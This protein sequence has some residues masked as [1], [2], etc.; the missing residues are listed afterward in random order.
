M[1]TTA[2]LTEILR[3]PSA[4]A[5]RIREGRD[6]RSLASASILAIVLGSAAY[7][8]VV[9]SYRGGLQILFGGLKFPLVALVTLSL[10]APALLGLSAAFERRMALA[11]AVALM[12][13][14][15]ARTSLVLLAFAPALAL[16]FDMRPEYH[17]GALLAAAGFALA[18]LAGITLLWRGLGEGEG[19]FTLAVLAVGVYV[20]VSGQAAWSLRP[21]LVRPSSPI[22]FVRAPHE[23]LVRELPRSIDSAGGNYDPE[24]SRARQSEREG[25]GVSSARS[26]GAR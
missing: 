21:W 12:L 11:Q 18:G 26:A 24:R 15:T 3:A 14:A 16:V 5:S 22:A 17:D 20:L 7:G 13:A 10:V 6:L 2:S 25:R 4:V 19:R 8:G 1:S 23:S 9:G